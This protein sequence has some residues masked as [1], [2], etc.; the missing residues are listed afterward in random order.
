M[1]GWTKAKRI[2]AAKKAARTRKRNAKA[3]KRKT[4]TRRKKR[5]IG[6]KK[7]GKKTWQKKASDK[8]SDSEGIYMELLKEEFGSESIIFKTGNAEKEKYPSFVGVPD[9]AI[10]I[11]K[12]LEF[13]EI[14]PA[15]PKRNQ[16]K[17]NEIKDLKASF[18]KEHQMNWIKNNCLEKGRRRL[19]PIVNL[20]FYKKGKNYTY[21]RKKL[22]SRNLAKYSRNS[23]EKSKKR[24]LKNIMKKKKFSLKYQ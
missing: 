10:Y 24:I 3:V 21:Y 8:I 1:S 23:D 6:K 18:L 2:A 4:P 20:V 9:I 15:I 11:N 17:K 5:V 19:S 14:K 16:N 22:T 13:Y 12:K 7:S